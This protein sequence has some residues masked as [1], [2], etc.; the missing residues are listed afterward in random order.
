MRARVLFAGECSIWSFSRRREVVVVSRLVR[1]ASVLFSASFFVTDC[2]PCASIETQEGHAVSQLA[3]VTC[4]SLFF[5]V[6]WRPN[7]FLGGCWGARHLDGSAF[8]IHAFRRHRP[9]R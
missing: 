1:L 9:F 4:N 2:D 8:C 7:S 6:C 3:P 5:W